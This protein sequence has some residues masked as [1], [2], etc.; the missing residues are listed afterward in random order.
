MLP[1]GHV[2]YMFLSN[3]NRI[4]SSSGPSSVTLHQQRCRFS[5]LKSPTCAFLTLQTLVYRTPRQRSTHMIRYHTL[6]LLLLPNGNVSY[7]FNSNLNRIIFSSSSPSSIALN[8]PRYPFSFLRAPACAFLP[9]R[10][11]VLPYSSST[12]HPYDTVHYLKY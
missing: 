5:F 3:L 8:Q 6:S 7:M 11:L 2:S 10:T 9:W 1:F 4:Y 12:F